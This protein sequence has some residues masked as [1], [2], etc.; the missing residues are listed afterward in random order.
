MA[1]IDNFIVPDEEILEGEEILETPLEMPR[2][3]TK[4]YEVKPLDRW[5]RVTDLKYRM[6]SLLKFQLDILVNSVTYDFDAVIIVDG[7]IEGSGK[8]VFAQQ[9]GYYMAWRGGRKLTIE[10][11]VFTPKQ[12]REAIEK[13]NKMECI[14]WDEAYSG[15]NKF[16]MMANIN[17]TISTML[18]KIRQKNLFIVVV[19]PYFFDLSSYIAVPRSWFLI[20]VN[21]KNQLEIEKEATELDFNKPIFVRGFFEFYSRKRKK[22]LYFQGRREY[23]YDY[24]RGNFIGNF[25]Q[26]Y[27][28]DEEAY[29]EKK[30]KYATDDDEDEQKRMP[31]SVWIEE[32]IMRGMSASEIKGHVGCSVQNIYRIKNKLEGKGI[33][34]QMDVDKE[35]A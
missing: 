29:K 15:A 2:I 18:Q 10:H 4:S 16:R 19:L 33:I 12:F 17:Q 20:H 28:V 9:V 23:N 31:E 7:E 3:A 30:L 27:C 5:N 35:E 26:F 11:I 22:A 1:E 24:V 13:A 25:P 14:I 21:L 8:S 32:A 6:N 34:T